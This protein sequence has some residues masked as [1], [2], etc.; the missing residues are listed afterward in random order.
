MPKRRITDEPNSADVTSRNLSARLLQVQ[1]EER[2]RIAREMHDSVGQLV[3][4]ISMNLGAVR[5]Q[6]DRL[7]AKGAKAVA[8][9]ILLVEEIEREIRTISHLLHPPLL[10]E[11]GLGSAIRWYVDE[12]SE[13]SK[14]SVDLSIPSDFG[15]LP[16]DMEIA[17]FRIVQEC[18]TNIHRHSGSATATINMVA[19]DSR[20]VVTV[21]DKGKGIP[22][23]RQQELNSTD[24][25]GVGFRG[26][27]ERVRQLGGSL[28][29]QSDTNG[30]VIFAT[31]PVPHT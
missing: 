20:I 23:K 16:N 9:T 22:L 19:E 7:D 8:E 15:R 30:T 21:Q 18:L 5:K 13:R 25:T 14:I 28:K 4:A 26:M 17:I 29:I 6:S 2:R 27:R 24:R 3:A 11:A 1:D 12:F 31:L 10:D